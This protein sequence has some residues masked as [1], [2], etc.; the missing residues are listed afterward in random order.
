L[1]VQSGSDDIDWTV[2][3]NGTS[4]A[5]GPLVDH[6][7][8]DPTGNY[9]YTEASVPCNLSKEAIL[10]SP[11]FDISA[12]TNPILSFW[13]FMYDGGGGNM[14]NLYTDIYSGGVWIT[15]DSLI[16]AQQPVQTDPW[17]QDT[18]DLSS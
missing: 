16:G 14:G 12:L 10:T 3:S 15:V 8:G 9:I 4:S 1:W 18:V 7:I 17:L 5:V 6:T 11:C 2:D 13:Y